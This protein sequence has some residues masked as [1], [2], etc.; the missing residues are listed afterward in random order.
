MSFD[1]EPEATAYETTAPPAAGQLSE[2]HSKWNR[3][4]S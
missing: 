2:S 3:G 1:P 4:I